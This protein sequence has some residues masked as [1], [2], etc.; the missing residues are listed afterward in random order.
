M[1][2]AM[3]V[4]EQHWCDK[5]ILTQAF[6]VEIKIGDAVLEAPGFNGSIKFERQACTYEL[7]NGDLLSDIGHFAPVIVI[8]DG[9]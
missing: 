6:G 9:R 5:A 2:I 4:V 3:I 7:I 8:R 1:M